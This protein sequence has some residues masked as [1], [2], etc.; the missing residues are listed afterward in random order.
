MGEW[1]VGDCPLRRRGCRPGWNAE[2][3]H[4]AVGDYELNSKQGGLCEVLVGGHLERAGRDWLARPHTLPGR[5]HF[6]YTLPSLAL[7]SCSILPCQQLEMSRE[8]VYEG[9]RGTHAE[10]WQGAF[11]VHGSHGSLPEP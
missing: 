10:L 5:I 8:G 9:F 6:S 7:C 1:C 11:L 2:T 4:Q 3:C